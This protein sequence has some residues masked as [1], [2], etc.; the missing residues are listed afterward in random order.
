MLDRVITSNIIQ[1]L[2]RVGASLALAASAERA[3][4]L[5]ANLYR[6]MYDMNTQ[7]HHGRCSLVQRH[8]PVIWVHALRSLGAQRSYCYIWRRGGNLFDF[9]RLWYGAF[10]RVN[11]SK[12]WREKWDKSRLLVN[13]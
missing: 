13:A 2:T 6:Q 10:S 4:T 3:N 11:G 5:C 7:T 12:A 8:T 1:Q 9:L